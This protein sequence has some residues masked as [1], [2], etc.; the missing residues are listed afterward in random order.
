MT[1]FCMITIFSL[2]VIACGDD[3]S[4]SGTQTEREKYI[5]VNFRLGVPMKDE[6]VYNRANE[7][8][9]IQDETEQSV[10]RLKIYDFIITSHIDEPLI[11]DTLFAGMQVLE[12]E[13]VGNEADLGV[14]KFISGNGMVNVRVAFPTAIIGS[15]H[16]FAFVAN[17]GTTKF[18]TD[19]EITGNQKITIDKFR[20]TPATKV[21]KDGDSSTVLLEGGTVMTGMSEPKTLTSSVSI[22]DMKLQRIVARIDVIDNIPAD[23]NFKLRSVN[24]SNTA[25]VGY[26]FERA[27]DNS[28]TSSLWAGEYEAV[29]SMQYKGM[30]QSSNQYKKVLYLYE[31]DANNPPTLI[32]EY[33]LN[34]SPGSQNVKM[35]DYLTNQPFDIHRNCIY[36]L[37][38]G[39]ITNS[40]LNYQ[41]SREEII[42]KE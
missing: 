13:D 8:D 33:T 22:T 10:N 17:E 28:L 7:G 14:G 5:V 32:I 29:K 25:P 11:A 21:L 12:K 20:K 18:D 36:T 19:I 40:M 23:K 31:S 37:K 27:S 9:P 35:E 16:V 26:L 1:A 34:G 39:E 42:N 6:V 38:I 4:M 2:L 41:V 15:R 30:E 3:S 24:I